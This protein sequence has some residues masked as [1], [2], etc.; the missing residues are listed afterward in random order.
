LHSPGVATILKLVPIQS[1]NDMNVARS[2]S[3]SWPTCCACSGLYCG[4]TNSVKSLK[5]PR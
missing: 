2:V 4:P 1:D 3:N 5:A